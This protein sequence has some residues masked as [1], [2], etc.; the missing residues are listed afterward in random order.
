MFITE[1]GWYRG[2]EVSERARFRMLHHVLLQRDDNRVIGQDYIPWE[3]G[4]MRHLPR[5]YLLLSYTHTHMWTRR[6]S[7]LS[8]TMLKRDKKYPYQVFIDLQWWRIHCFP[9]FSVAGGTSITNY[10]LS[11][12]SPAAFSAVI[13]RLLGVLVTREDF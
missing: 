1:A 5:L 13:S 11:Q 7:C 3:V 9:W 12:L 6:S 8:S 4:K 2:V 10:K